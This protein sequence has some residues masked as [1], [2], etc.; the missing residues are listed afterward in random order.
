MVFCDGSPKNPIHDAYCLCKSTLCDLS[1]HP[2]K[3]TERGMLAACVC[4]DLSTVQG[5]A[6]GGEAI[7][8][9][10]SVSSLARVSC[11]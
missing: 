8:G 1:I 6:K 7:S 5:K 10:D 9:G 2:W 3:S 4:V 11:T